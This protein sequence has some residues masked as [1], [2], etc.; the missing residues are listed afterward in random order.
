VCDAEVI[1]ATFCNAYIHCAQLHLHCVAAPWIL[2]VHPVTLT[3]FHLGGRSRRNSRVGYSKIHL[4]GIKYIKRHHK[5]ITF[6]VAIENYQ[7][8]YKNSG[9]TENKTFLASDFSQEFFFVS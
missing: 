9:F 5:D 2:P 1:D 4:G 3:E 6:G 8:H 7:V